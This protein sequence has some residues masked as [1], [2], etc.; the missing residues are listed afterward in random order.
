MVP[1]QARNGKQP[2]GLG[3]EI[4]GRKIMDPGINQKD[5]GNVFC[6]RI[7]GDLFS[8]FYPRNYSIKKRKS[9]AITWALSSVIFKPIIPQLQHSIIPL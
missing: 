7:V 6:H 8:V 4:I 3:P 2:H 9:N 1:Q 5:M